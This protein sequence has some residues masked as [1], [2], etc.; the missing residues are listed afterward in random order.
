MGQR[1][2]IRT[3]YRVVGIGALV[4]AGAIALLG[5]GPAGPGGPAPAA[6]PTS[7]T[8]AGAMA[9][10]GVP[11][12]LDRRLVDVALLRPAA[13]GGDPRL[14]TVA[15]ETI[16]GDRIR[17]TVLERGLD[18]WLARTEIDQP[19]PLPG[20][21][22]TPWLVALDDRRFVQI[23]VVPRL[24][25]T[26]LRTV[27][28]SG[29]E[30]RLGE[31][32]R[33]RRS[34]DDAG[35]ADVDG[36]GTDELVLVEAATSR[37][38]SACQG[39][40]LLIADPVTL[41]VQRELRV[42]NLRLGPGVVGQLDDVPGDDLASI[43]QR[44]CP[45]GPSSAHRMALV[46]VR[47]AD[48]GVLRDWQLHAADPVTAWAGRPSVV[49]IQR[50]GRAE[51]LVGSPD[52]LLVVSPQRD[53]EVREL[54]SLPGV[55][56]GVRATAER[57]P[58]RPPGASVAVVTMDDHAV[59]AGEIRRTREGWAVVA[60]GRLTA[61]D[62]G[63]A[64]W[65]AA[66]LDRR[67]AS[68]RLRGGTAWLTGDDRCPT[69]VVPLAVVPCAPDDEPAGVQVGT[70][71]LG[72]RPVAEVAGGSRLLVAR[73]DVWPG[74]ATRLVGPAPLAV[75]PAGHSWRHG[76]SSSFVLAEADPARLT[77][78][79]VEPPLLGAA[80]EGDPPHLPMQAT[81]GSRLVV[82]VAPEPE[83]LRYGRVSLISL[84]ARA[85]RGDPEVRFELAEGPEGGRAEIGLELPRQPE[86][87]PSDRVWAVAAAAIGPL[88]EVSPLAW[89]I[90]GLDSAPPLVAVE[91]P[92]LSAPW[93]LT[94]RLAGITEPG[95][96]V[97]AGGR[98]QVAGR[99]GRFRI[100]AQLPPWPQRVEVRA[101]DRAG[102]ESVVRVDV[103]G[104]IDYRRLP[105]IPILLV[106]LLGA[107]VLGTRRP[108]RE[109]PAP[110]PAGDEGARPVLEE[111]TAGPIDPPRR[112]R[113]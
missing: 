59:R 19:V 23:A 8:G 102:N 79:A 37:R 108:V 67:N 18:R 5:G 47:L 84:L 31:P 96:V 77:D 100:D 95:A 70:P 29:E 104:G 55:L 17:L 3:G 88:G 26:W 92:F 107:A 4:T 33:V 74:G 112:G 6:G 57:E 50:D 105:W 44:T 111:L 22:D 103:V 93:P 21:T 42:P 30:L 46:A 66:E 80:A 13:P 94:A 85:A 38:G 97:E 51:L 12:L 72:T 106:G 2:R 109:A 49:D 24:A 34:I 71:W 41:G 78:P 40:T 54:V 91:A 65:A 43:A 9:D 48:G 98:E 16:S 62:V 27:A 63:Q 1:R 11:D 99:D 90:V 28:W 83:R 89:T 35:T 75:A 101:R 32:V 60:T 7:P 81:D 86:L 110:T 53:W 87:A 56:L 58:Q 68:L 76:P 52:G 14:L 15:R 113:G 73:S 36:D 69:L 20:E 82:A 10:A 45:A 64:S 25:E 39:S 61:A